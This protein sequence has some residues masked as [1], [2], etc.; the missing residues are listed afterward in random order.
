L[1]LYHWLTKQGHEVEL[2]VPSDY[3]SFLF[4]MPGQE[5]AIIYTSHK[6]NSDKLIEQ[7]D[8]IFC[9]D[10]NHLSR[11]QSMEDVVR[12]STALKVMIDHHIGP[13]DFDNAR[14]WDCKAAATA[15]LVYD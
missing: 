9:L 15:Q 14:L 1:A 8:I 3:P 7:A 10:F 13:E 2:I 12:K 4:C 11:I 6:E 5:N